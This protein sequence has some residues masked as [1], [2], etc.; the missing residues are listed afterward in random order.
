MTSSLA[1]SS[2]AT[3]ARV[4]KQHRAAVGGIALIVA[5]ADGLGAGFGQVVERITTEVP[6]ACTPMSV[7]VDVHS[8]ALAWEIA[9]G[10]DATQYAGA[11]SLDR[12]SV[13]RHATEPDA[14][15][16]R[17]L[18]TPDEEVGVACETSRP[19]ALMHTPY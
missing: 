6:V 8:T 13:D 12:H 2:A 10:G 3:V 18:P 5:V 4:W 14:T 15:G 16:G 7:S 1:W 17:L 19:L 9:T 11:A